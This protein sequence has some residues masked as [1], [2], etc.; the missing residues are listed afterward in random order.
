MIDIMESRK[1]K[2]RSPNFP[3][4]TLESA[5]ERAQQFYDKEKRSGAPFPVTAGHWGYSH[6]VV[7]RYR[8]CL[9]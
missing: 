2:E 8:R 1:A 4:I 3:F 6:Q 7:E 5:I 9:H